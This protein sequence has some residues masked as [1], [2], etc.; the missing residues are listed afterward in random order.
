MQISTLRYC[1]SPTEPRESPEVELFLRELRKAHLATTNS[2]QNHILLQ[3]MRQSIIYLHQPILNAYPW[4]QPPVT[5]HVPHP[6]VVGK[7]KGHTLDLAIS[8]MVD[9][10]SVLECATDH[11]D[12]HQLF[13]ENSLA[14]NFIQMMI[15]KYVNNNITTPAE[16]IHRHFAN[17]RLALQG[18]L[19]SMNR[20]RE[21]LV[22][23]PRMEL[24]NKNYKPSKMWMKLVNLSSIDEVLAVSTSQTC[25][26]CFDHDFEKQD[27]A[28]LNG[29]RHLFCISCIEEYFKQRYT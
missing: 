18:L 27:F 19:D 17:R 22:L 28:I 6:Y 26:I 15:G 12:D 16:I 10:P 7:M 23:L 11:L 25:S 13:V 24:I 2:S 20:T 14:L 8:L 5:N 21:E 4:N 9:R 29:C 3:K 1:P